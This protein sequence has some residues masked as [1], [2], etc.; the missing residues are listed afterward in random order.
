MESNTLG[1][2]GLG[3]MGGAMVRNLLKAGYEVVAFYLD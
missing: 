2:L 1:F 3:D